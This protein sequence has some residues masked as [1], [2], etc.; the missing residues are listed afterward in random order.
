[1]QERN[2]DSENIVRENG[3]L[4]FE[5][6]NIPLVCYTRTKKGRTEDDK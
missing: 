2:V 5:E 6:S 4:R 3:V 1:M